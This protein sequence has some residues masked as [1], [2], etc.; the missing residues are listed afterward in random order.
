I[1]ETPVKGKTVWAHAFQ[2]TC[3]QLG[4]EHRLTKPKHRW[5]NGQVERMNRTIKG[6]TVKCY[7]YG[8]HDQF[9]RHFAAFV[10]A[11]NFG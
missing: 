1:V 8:S 2:Y 4:I 7:H 11:Y 10:S 6:A 3:A 9:G 5:T